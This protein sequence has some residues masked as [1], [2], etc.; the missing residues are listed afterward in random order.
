ML[1]HFADAQA[2]MTLSVEKVSVMLQR[3]EQRTAIEVI[4]RMTWPCETLYKGETGAQAVSLGEKGQQV[5]EQLMNCKEKMQA[6]HDLLQGLG[7]GGGKAKKSDR[8]TEEPSSDFLKFALEGARRTGVTVHWVATA[9]QLS[10]SATEALAAQVGVEQVAGRMSLDSQEQDSCTILKQLG[11]PDAQLAEAQAHVIVAAMHDQLR[12]HATQPQKIL[13]FVAALMKCRILDSSLSG[14]LNDLHV[15][16]HSDEADLPRLEEAV[17]QTNQKQGL[18]PLAELVASEEFSQIVSQAK[19]AL[20]GAAGTL[21]NPPPPSSPPCCLLAAFS[22]PLLPHFLCL[23]SPLAPRCPPL[24]SCPYFSP[25]SPLSALAAGR[26]PL[27]CASDGPSVGTGASASKAFSAELAKLKLDVERFLAPPAGGAAATGGEAAPEAVSAQMSHVVFHGRGLGRFSGRLEL[28]RRRAVGLRQPQQTQLEALESLL[29]AQVAAL[30]NSQ[31]HLAVKCFPLKTMLQLLQG[32]RKL[33]DAVHAA[34]N[35]RQIR[36]CLTA[37]KDLGFPSHDPESLKLHLGQLNI[38]STLQAAWATFLEE[39]EAEDP[40]ALFTTP[41]F[42]KFQASL[43]AAVDAGLFAL[44]QAAGSRQSM[45]PP[46]CRL[47]TLS[48][49]ASDIRLSVVV[50]CRS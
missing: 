25:S 14:F 20:K 45:W 26:S 35:T 4:D 40:V 8:A 38:L 34:L 5:V 6:G 43:T 42:A 12:I 29:Q 31:V 48:L 19:G 49:R 10:L 36:H 39:W 33:A 37:P 22:S 41:R 50:L 11:L 16:F 17:Q 47:D 21:Y 32:D 9:R 44:E 7:L 1:E 13:P 46:C 2:L 18:G 28:L 27:C 24:V 23:L 3:V 30:Q 15:L